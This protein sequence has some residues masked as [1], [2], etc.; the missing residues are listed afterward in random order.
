MD[1]PFLIGL[2]IFL[3]CA[4]GSRFISERAM[5]SLPAEQKVK[6]IDAFSGMRMYGL[7]WTIGLLGVYFALPMLLPDSPVLSLSI[8]LGLAVIFLVV[9]QV[10]VRD[11]L[12]ALDVDAAYKRKVMMAQLLIGLGLAVFIGCVVVGVW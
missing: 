6:L 7:L 5:R 10:T 4:F 8:G 12:N 1:T 3:L 11:K 2:I 9:R